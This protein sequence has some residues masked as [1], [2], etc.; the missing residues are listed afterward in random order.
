MVDHGERLRMKLIRY[1]GER[2]HLK[3]SNFF[4][5]VCTKCR[6]CGAVV[7]FKFL[8]RNSVQL[9]FFPAPLAMDGAISGAPEEQY[10]THTY[11]FKQS[12]AN[13]SHNEPS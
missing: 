4:Q 3:L 9:G 12:C 11:V 10:S 1:H 5:T 2:V 13:D 8:E 7:N 6:N